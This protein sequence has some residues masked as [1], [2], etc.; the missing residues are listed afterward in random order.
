M[1]K[2]LSHIECEIEIHIVWTT[3]YRYKILTGK[4]AKRCRNL[5]IQICRNMEIDLLKGIME[6]D[7]VYIVLSIPPELLKSI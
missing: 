3:K 7:Y 1:M 2:K 4:V 6:K 5:L